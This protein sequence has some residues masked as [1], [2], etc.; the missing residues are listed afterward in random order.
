MGIHIVWG[1]RMKKIRNISIIGECKMQTN[2]G[3]MTAPIN[4]RSIDPAL[5][6]K[7]V[8]LEISGFFK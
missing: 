4:G 1:N 7:P 2:I 8:G 6:V 3:S 5:I